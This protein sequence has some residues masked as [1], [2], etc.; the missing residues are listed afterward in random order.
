MHTAPRGRGASLNPLNRFE[1]IEVEMEVPGP[2]RVETQILRDGS[3][4]IITRNDSPDVGFEFSLNPYRGCEHGCIYCYARPTHE[5]LGFSAGLDFETRIMAKPDAPELLRKEL[6][7]PRWKPKTLAMSGVTDPYQPPERNLEITRR[8]LKVLAEFRHPVSVITKNELVTRDI[9]VLS[10]LAS[11][12]AVAVVLS[13]TTL[14]PEVARKMEPRASHPR[15]RL[16]AIERLAAAGIPVGVNVAPVVPAITDHEIPKILEAAAAAGA[17]S[18]GYVMLRLP[19]AVAGLFENWL[20]EHFPDRKDKVLNRVRGLRGGKLNDPRFGSRMRGEGIFADQVDAVF[21]TARRRYG[22]D[23][24]R[25]E[26]NADAF[27]RP[28]EVVQ[29]GL[30]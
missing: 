11:H 10:E 16:K 23:G 9:D 19:G 12:N 21:E 29:L 15:D 5:Y 3:R 24:R 7:S 30:F 26:V 6:S 2:E 8:C 1:H 20:E 27:R 13:I 17:R 4:S 22:F 14:D 18:A 25:F 28:G